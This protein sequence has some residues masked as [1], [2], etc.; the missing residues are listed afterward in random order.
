MIS[1]SADNEKNNAETNI[2]NEEE[3]E[4]QSDSSEKMKKA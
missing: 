2:K 4:S 3:K 1:M